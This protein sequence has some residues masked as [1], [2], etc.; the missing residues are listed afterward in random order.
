M[1]HT[2]E[3]APARYP[4]DEQ[5]G[6]NN[7]MWSFSLKNCTLPKQHIRMAGL[8]LL[9]L[10]VL[11][12]FGV[13][14]LI[15]KESNKINLSQDVS[16]GSTENKNN[17]TNPPTNQPTNHPT[18]PVA[19]NPTSPLTR[20]PTRFP[21]H[22][23]TSLPTMDIQMGSD[24]DG[25]AA[26]DSFGS[27]VALSADGSRVAIG[28][29]TNKDQVRIFDWTGSQWI[30]VGSDL[31]GDGTDDEFGYS[32]ALSADGNRVAIGAM[33]NDDNGEDSGHVRILDW[34]GSQWMQVGSNLDGEAPGYGFGWSVALSGDGNR[35][36]IGAP[37]NGGNGAYSG[38]A[39]IYDWTGSQWI[40]VGSQL[41]G[42]A[43]ED[44]FGHDVALSADGSRVV[45]GAFASGT[46]TKAGYARIFDWTGSQWAQVGSDLDG[47]AAGDEFGYSV[48][49]S[50]DGN[51]VAIGASSNTGN[52]CYAGHV[53]IFD[54]T[55]SQWMQVGSDLDGEAEN[56]GSGRSVA[57]TAD[58][59]R[60]AIGAPWNGADF[61]S[62]GH[63]RI[64]DWTGS[65]W[66]QVGYDLDG[67][68][69]ENYSGWSVALSEDGNRVAIGAPGNDFSSGHV[70]IYDLGAFS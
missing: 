43:V 48:S 28:A 51:R 17:P 57:L 2:T 52:G 13:E 16:Q 64:Y 38:H 27:S 68:A 25:E 12:G 45:M 34:T 15:T 9:L 63:V 56:D 4:P 53:R 42:D 1:H 21:T 35:V 62:Q 60:V 8:V 29:S 70:R 22:P 41:D 40:Q 65:Q 39:R 32:V 47:E 26:F 55:G 18:K 66:M 10:L 58:G 6:A 44:W 5:N 49:L 36:A 67:E 24:L 59:N 37:W 19:I 7:G 11:L 14:K 69:S 50:A 31:E 46:S 3:P 61:L 33:Y 20:P 30:Q 54:W 23:P